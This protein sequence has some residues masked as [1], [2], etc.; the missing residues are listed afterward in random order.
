MLSTAA[1][2]DGVLAEGRVVDLPRAVALPLLEGGYAV[3]LEDLASTSASEA[4]AAVV[5]PAEAAVELVEE[6]AILEPLEVAGR[7]RRKGR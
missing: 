5:E 3:A 2:P 7:K 1:G 4:E 6:K